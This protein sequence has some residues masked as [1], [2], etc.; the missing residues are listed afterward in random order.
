MSKCT[1]ESAYQEDICTFRSAFCG[2]FINNMIVDYYLSKS[3]IASAF[4]LSAT[5]MYGFIAL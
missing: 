2:L 1:V 3:F 4:T 5:A